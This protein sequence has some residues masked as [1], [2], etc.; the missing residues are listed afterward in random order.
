MG[1][2]VLQGRSL[3]E[4]DG[5]NA[6]LVVVV[7][8]RVA[9]LAWPGESPIGKRVRGGGHRPWAEVVGVVGHIRHESL[10]SDRRLQIYWNY[11]QR[12]RDGMTLVVRTSGDARHLVSSVLGVIKAVDPDQP[13]YAVRTMTEV[14]DQSLSLR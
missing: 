6:P 11:L 2:P 10:E 12:T 14:L 4:Q 7:D 9:R 5:T 1:I 13:A 3:T 8:E